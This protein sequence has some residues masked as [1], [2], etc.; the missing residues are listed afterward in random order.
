LGFNVHG[1]VNFK[2]GGKSEINDFDSGEVV[3]VFEQDVFYL[4][5]EILAC[6]KV[7]VNDV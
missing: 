1:V 5:M 3:A 7:P 6:F 4:I 2:L